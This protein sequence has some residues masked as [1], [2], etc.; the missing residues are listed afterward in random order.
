MEKY[1]IRKH[2]T[3]SEDIEDKMFELM[4]MT[5]QKN[6]SELVRTL[7]ADKYREVTRG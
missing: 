7:V 3:V 2:I 4:Y 1:P 5:R 6:V